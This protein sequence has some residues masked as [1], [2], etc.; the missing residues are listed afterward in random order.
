MNNINHWL[1]YIPRTLF[2]VI[3]FSSLFSLEL[4]AQF[5]VEL[6]VLQGSVSTTCT[7]PPF[8]IPGTPAWG[9]AVENEPVKFYSN[10]CPNFTAYPNQNI[11]HYS[12]TVD[13]ISDLSG[14]ELFV[15]LWAFDNDPGFLGDPCAL[16]PDE[17]KKGCLEVLCNSFL[18]PVPGTEATYT[19]DNSNF[20]IDPANSVL[21]STGSVTFK[22]AVS[23]DAG[24]NNIATND[25][26]CNAIELPVITT[27]V[28]APEQYNNYCTTNTD[29][30]ITGFNVTNSVWFKFTPSQ[31]RRVFINAF[32][33]VPGISSDPIDPEVAIFYAPTDECDGALEEVTYQSPSNNGNILQLECLNPKFTYYI[34]VDGTNADPT[35]IFSVDVIERGYPDAIKKDTFICRG[36]V[37]DVGAK[38]YANTGV[39]LD[40]LVN[41]DCVEILETNL[42]VVEPIALDLRVLSLARGEG[43]G[44]GAVNASAQF[45]TGSYAYEWSSGQTNTVANN[46]IGGDQYCVTIT[47]RNAGCS[48][49]T[50]FNMEF[51]IPITADVINDTL[52]C[53]YSEFGQIQLTVTAG[54]P[55]YQYRLQG[56]SDPSVIE[57]GVIT[58]NDSIFLIED[59]PVGTFNIF[60]DNAE[61]GQ[62]FEAEVEAPDPISITL[63][64]QV[65]PD[66]AGG[67]TGSLQVEA[68]GGIGELDADFRPRPGDIEFSEFLNI[69]QTSDIFLPM[70]DLINLPAA[71]YTIIVEDA[72]GCRDSTAY[73]ITEP[74]AATLNFVNVQPVDCF[75]E[76]NG[77]ATITSNEPIASVQWSNG[78]TTETVTSL[79]AEIHKVTLINNMGCEST[80]SIFIPQPSNALTANIDIMEE[81]ACGGDTNGVLADASRGGNGNYEYIWSTGATTDFIDNLPAGTYELIVRDEKG[82]LDDTTVTLLEPIPIDA[83]VSS[84]DVTCPAGANSGIITL[85]NPTG[86]TAPYRFSV[87]NQGFINNMEITNLSAGTYAVLMQDDK[88]CEKT[89]DQV[90]IN[91]PPEVTVNLG[92]DMQITLGQTVELKATANRMVTYEWFTTDSLSCLDCATVSGLPFNNAKYSVRVTDEATGC[93]AED[94]IAVTVLKTRKLFVPNAFSPNGDGINDKLNLFGGPEITKVLRFEIY[95]RDGALVYQKNNFDLGNGI[96]WD[97]EYQG[98]KLSTDVFIYFA[99]VEYVDNAVELFKGDFTLIR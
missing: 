36:T 65:N 59:I 98:Q 44:G 83:I 23:E 60:V 87:N 42:V 79:T 7:D 91:N 51:P 68:S 27:A 66:C 78:E 75:G 94:E 38:S 26:I 73:T 25:R 96:G 58:K 92:A 47:D 39:Y 62:R 50:C 74:E 20:V 67:A 2:L 12:T 8:G 13:C 54:K 53:S 99:E 57:N 30:P 5:T 31:S 46:L 84:Q 29:D 95:S 21:E 86:G 40:T 93:T 15:C 28:N 63:L 52:N 10:D 89:F 82:C 76:A 61:G 34:L 18:I 97:G 16:T 69:L 64:E 72:N 48:V 88:G 35:G 70:V 43:E 55:P 90:I 37:L 33:G 32:G 49:D 45:G 77:Q 71:E 41:G 85:N 17:S 3:I 4:S 81:I 11:I 56:I 24:N 9:V 1:R 6:T 80:D 19:L 14:G 22:I